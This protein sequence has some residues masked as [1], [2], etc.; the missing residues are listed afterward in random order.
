MDP[1]NEESREHNTH[2]N[3]ADSQVGAKEKWTRVSKNL[4]LINFSL[5]P[6]IG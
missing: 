5:L 3:V 2:T 4:N 6:H 1:S